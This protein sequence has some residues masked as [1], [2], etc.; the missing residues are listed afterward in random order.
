MKRHFDWRESAFTKRDSLRSLTARMTVLYQL[1]R[2]APVDLGEMLR[3]V[4][5][6]GDRVGTVVRALDD[7]CS[8]VETVLD[9]VS[10]VHQR[11]CAQEEDH[12]GDPALY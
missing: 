8:T 2:G 9:L 4:V 7:L 5:D 10:E 12:D 1:N 11:V 6:L 3:K